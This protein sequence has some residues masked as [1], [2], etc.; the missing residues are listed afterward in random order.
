VYIPDIDDFN[1]YLP[2]DIGGLTLSLSD[3][4]IDK[5]VL[6]SEESDSY[7]LVELKKKSMRFH[8][9]NFSTRLWVNYKYITDP[10]LFMDIGQFELDI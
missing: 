4:H 8:I 9:S 2:H 6:E 7:Q 3:W 10:G 5:L 1:L